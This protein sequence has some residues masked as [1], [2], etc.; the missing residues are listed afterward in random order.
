MCNIFY[1]PRVCQQINYI[2]E[3]FHIK[4]TLIFKIY[5]ICV[6]YYFN[7]VFFI[8]VIILRKK[9]VEEEERKKE[10]EERKDIKAAIV[11]LIFSFCC[12]ISEQK[13]NLVSV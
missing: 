9:E 4:R 8:L 7:Y 3:F 13:L 10:R 12:L 6:V 1:T 5:K 11:S 2:I